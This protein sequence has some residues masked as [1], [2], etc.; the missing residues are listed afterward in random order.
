MN[1]EK[2]TGGAPDRE[3]DIESM[4]PED[5]REYVLAYITA[6]KRLQKEIGVLQ[7]QIQRWDS[8]VKAARERDESLLASSTQGQVEKLKSEL[9]IRRREEETLG[10]KVAL[11]KKKLQAIRA[12]PSLAV[13]PDALLQQLQSLTGEPDALSRQLREQEAQA[14][15]EELKRKMQ[16]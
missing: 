2:D 16:K 5:A 8:R 12:R 3:L 11:L 15:L 4:K 10:R 14:A 13:D 1:E 7:E 6:W 9:E